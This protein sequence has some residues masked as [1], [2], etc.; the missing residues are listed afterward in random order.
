MPRAADVIPQ[1]HICPACL[2]KRGERVPLTAEH[3]NAIFWLAWRV[4]CP[5]CGWD[6]S[7]ERLP[8]KWRFLMKYVYPIAGFACILALMYFWVWPSLVHQLGA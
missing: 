1:D 5:K 7:L 6:Q 4:Y 2:A 3:I 8:R